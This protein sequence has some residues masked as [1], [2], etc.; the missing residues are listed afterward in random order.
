MAWQG[1][2]MRTLKKGFKWEELVEEIV[3]LGKSM[4]LKVDE[5]DVNHLVE[6]CS[7]E[8]TIEEL[9]ELQKQNMEF[10]QDIAIK[11]E[12]KVGQVI[13]TSE[14]RELLGM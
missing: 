1:V 5:E 9:K 14:I 2:V 8:L 6:K 4:G 10:S 3:V 11:E 12:K 7:E 13:S